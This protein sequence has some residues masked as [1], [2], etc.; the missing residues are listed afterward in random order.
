MSTLL[1]LWV[2]MSDTWPL[3][4]LTEWGPRPS[5]CRSGVPRP[6]AQYSRAS[7]WPRLAQSPVDATFMPRKETQ[8]PPGLNFTPAYGLRVTRV[9]R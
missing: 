7:R 6:R 3:P 5:A 4:V 9:V 2:Q 8:G 1:A